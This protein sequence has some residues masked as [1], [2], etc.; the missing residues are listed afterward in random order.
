MRDALR[1]TT[2]DAL[3]A[4]KRDACRV[5]SNGLMSWREHVVGASAVCESVKSWMNWHERGVA[6]CEEVWISCRRAEH[7][8]APLSCQLQLRHES[9]EGDA[10]SSLG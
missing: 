6:A 1:V 9:D 8:R 2:R 7:N 4:T 5:G 10:V 3:R